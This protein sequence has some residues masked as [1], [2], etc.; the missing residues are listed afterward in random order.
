M[1]ARFALAVLACL[2][3]CAQEFE[4]ASI[5]PN[6][7]G[8][9][10]FGNQAPPVGG[11]EAKNISLRRLIAVAYAVPDHQIIGDIEWL[12]SERFDVS[13]KGSHHVELSE[14][15]LML[16]SLLAERFNLKIHPETRELPRFSLTLIKPGVTGPGLTPSPGVCGLDSGACETASIGRG[17]VNAQRAFISHL[18]DRLADFLGEMVIDNT[19]LAG[20]WDIKLTWTPDAEPGTA[21]YLAGPSFFTAIQ[22]QLGLKLQSGKG[23][24]PVVVVDSA[25]RPASN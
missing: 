21:A 17:R 11:Y 12:D 2:P 15:R 7:S 20:T 16:R 23:P 18:A 8:A 9:Y 10:G 19:G 22:E 13:A 6:L 1:K 4:V 25:E 3:A 14:L 24:V 5:K